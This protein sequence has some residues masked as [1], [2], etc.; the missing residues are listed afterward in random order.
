MGVLE[1]CKLELGLETENN[2]EKT[3]LPQCFSV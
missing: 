2:N 1:S 3:L